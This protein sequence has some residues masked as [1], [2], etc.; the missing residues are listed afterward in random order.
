MF[1]VYTPKYE[2][3]D[4]EGGKPPATQVRFGLG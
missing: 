2:K 3:E 4:E 1:N